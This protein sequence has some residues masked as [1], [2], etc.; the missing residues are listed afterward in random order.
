MPDRISQYQQ[1]RLLIHLPPR[2]PG[3][4]LD[5]LG[6]ATAAAGLVTTTKGIPNYRC[7]GSSP[8]YLPVRPM[9]DPELLE[10]LWEASKLVQEP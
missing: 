1:L 8:L 5:D 10:V 7:L 3:F 9:T 4:P 6:R 2:L